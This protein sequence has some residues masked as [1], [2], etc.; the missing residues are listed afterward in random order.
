MSLK[1]RLEISPLASRH[2]SGVAQYTRLLAE[3][4]VTDKNIQVSGH[5][6]DF[7]GRQPKPNLKNS[8]IAL[9]PNRFIPLRVYAK[10][11]SYG[12]ALPFDI[13]PPPKKAVDLT[14]YANF[15]T[16]PAFRT[17]MRATVIHDLTYL[18]FPEVTEEK[19]LAHLKRVVPRSIKLADFIITV[20]EAV[21]AELIKEFNLSP[22]R[23]IVTP[24]PPDEVFFTKVNQS[25]IMQV[26]EKYGINPQNKYIYFIGNK[27]PRKNLIGLI[28][29]YRLLPESVKREYSLVLAGGNGW[30]TEQ[31]DKAL[32]S[33]LAANENITH[34]GFVDQKDSPALYQ[35]AS[36]F[37]MP[38]LYEGFGMPILEAMASNCQVL[39]N[40]IPVLRE[41][42]GKSAVYADAADA[43]AFS[44][45]IAK[46]L[47][48]PPHKQL[49]AQAKYW[50]W[51]KNVRTII[52]RI[53][54]LS[55][56]DS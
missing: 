39:A 1:V 51:E 8:R 3:A 9:E 52:K 22:D 14:L 12:L 53:E 42:G 38:S 21:K 17:K 54:L 4:L 33:A 11:Q 13:L 49:S 35:G 27:E 40:D 36:L 28:A 18:Y 26:K 46:C 20:S 15:A 6:F 16:W 29:A 25:Q 10:L 7:L 34:I 5:F 23:C 19:N 30:K 37:V 31:T 50:S 45:A 44:K 24:I 56:D 32:A 48:T 47:K 2:Q 41:T 43:I 55:Q